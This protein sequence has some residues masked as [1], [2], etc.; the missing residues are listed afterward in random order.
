MHVITQ[1]D[2]LYNKNS[3]EWIVVYRINSFTIYVK[4]KFFLLS[5]DVR[6]NNVYNKETKEGTF[7]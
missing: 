6:K 4:K 5:K 7:Q 1:W 2:V 3:N